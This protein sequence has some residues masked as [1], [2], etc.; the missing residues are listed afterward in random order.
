MA[1]QLPPGSNWSHLESEGLTF[2][3]KLS[4]I[5]SSSVDRFPALFWIL[6]LGLLKY[7]ACLGRFALHFPAFGRG[8]F[9]LANSGCTGLGSRRLS[10]DRKRESISSGPSDPADGPGLSYSQK[11]FQCQDW[12]SAMR[13]RMMALAIADSS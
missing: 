12:E 8:S 3:R 10:A 9:Y 13:L 5:L 6:F 7:R 11:R 2:R 4:L 1:L